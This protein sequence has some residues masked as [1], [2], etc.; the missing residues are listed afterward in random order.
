MVKLSQHLNFIYETLSSITFF[1]NDRLAETFG[2]VQLLCLKVLNLIND[3][4]LSFPKF[5]D[6]L[7]LIMKSS[8]VQFF[9][10]VVSPNFKVIF[11]LRVSQFYILPIFVKSDGIALIDIPFRIFLMC[12]CGFKVRPDHLET[13]FKA[14]VD[15]LNLFFF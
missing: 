5:V 8:L 2:S 10:Q 1:I 13:D 6:S 15:D 11:F 14:E 4:E 12:L 3:S 7:E 9:L